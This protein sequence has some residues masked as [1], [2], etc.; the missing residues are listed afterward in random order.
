M[1]CPEEKQQ[2][3]TASVVTQTLDSASLIAVSSVLDVEPTGCFGVTLWAHLVKD[4][5][6]HTDDAT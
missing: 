6:P 3:Q 1:I 5:K 2:R 4:V